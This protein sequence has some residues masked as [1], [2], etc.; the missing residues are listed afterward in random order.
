MKCIICGE[1]N[2]SSV[3]HVFPNAIGGS[4]KINNVCLICN[5]NMGKAI[6]IHLSG[7]FVVLMAML[8]QGIRGKNGRMKTDFY[9]RAL[10]SEDG[11]KYEYVFNEDGKR[12]RLKHPF[13]CYERG[14]DSGQRMFTIVADISDMKKM[15]N[16][17]NG[18]RKKI[19]L[20]PISK[21]D[22]NTD[23]EKV[24]M[25]VPSQKVKFSINFDRLS[26]A[27]YKIAY[28]LA[29]LWLGE[30]YFND[31][32]AIKIRKLI[33]DAI[34]G[35]YSKEYINNVEIFSRDKY[36]GD[37]YEGKPFYNLGILNRV[38]KRLFAQIRIFNTLIGHFTI[39]ENA[40]A[41]ENFTPKIV[42]N[43]AKRRN[44]EILSVE[45][46][47]IRLYGELMQNG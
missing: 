22:L 5:S 15:L 31:K 45:D 10:Q 34:E 19:G 12:K 40:D 18:K 16:A 13:K 28:E 20:R 14:L 8:T 24:D 25:G 36:P 43:D 11:D 32:W 21:E 42:L 2:T 9:N 47:K 41:Y 37:P 23:I 29:F 38:K 33:N 30:G 35:E 26:V 17:L 27:L 44:H 39:S 3:E 46:A 1:E 7:S 4:L 6:D